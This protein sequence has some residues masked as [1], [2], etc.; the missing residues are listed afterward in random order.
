MSEQQEHDEAALAFNPAIIDQG[1]H[2][3][4]TAILQS[5]RQPK[6]AT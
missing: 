1:H 2:W 5:F 3:R 6:M 4:I